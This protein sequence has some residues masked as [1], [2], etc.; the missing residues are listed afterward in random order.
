[1][2]PICLEIVHPSRAERGYPLLMA[3]EGFTLKQYRII[4]S[5]QELEGEQP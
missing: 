5:T 1:M 3:S 2:I 4:W